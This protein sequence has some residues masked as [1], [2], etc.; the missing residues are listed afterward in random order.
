M[1]REAR[2]HPFFFFPGPVKHWQNCSLWSLSEEKEAG[3]PGW[4]VAGEA[5]TPSGCWHLEPRD[6]KGRCLPCLPLGT[7]MLN[8][9]S[10][11]HRTAKPTS[12]LRHQH[13]HFTCTVCVTFKLKFLN[14]KSLLKHFHPGPVSAPAL[15]WKV[16]KAEGVCLKTLV[17][18]SL[19]SFIANP[20]W[21]Q[22]SAAG[23]FL[24]FPES[25][26]FSIWKSVHSHCFEA[27]PW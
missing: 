7:V 17:C 15:T 3:Q 13:L 24:F 11:L 8:T 19:S 1:G 27:Y 23:Q 26:G 18:L 14:G 21:A 22:V 10:I 4:A 6:C 2:L 16:T 9:A 20:H 12:S 25:V 5:N